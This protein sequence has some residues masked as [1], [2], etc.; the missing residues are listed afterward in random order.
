MSES[1]Q[2][3]DDEN[4]KDF[5]TNGMSINI[6]SGAYKISSQRIPKYTIWIK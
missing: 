4:R 3:L 1:G 5:P 2:K 6:N